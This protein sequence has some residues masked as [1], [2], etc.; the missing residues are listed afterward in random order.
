MEIGSILM[1]HEDDRINLLNV[2]FQVRL[3]IILSMHQLLHHIII[4]QNSIGYNINLMQSETYTQL[5]TFIQ[6]THTGCKPNLKSCLRT[7]GISVLFDLRL[8]LKRLYLSRVTQHL[9]AKSMY[10]HGKS[11]GMKRKARQ[12]S[13]F[14]KESRRLKIIIYQLIAY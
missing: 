8:W 4:Y 12:Y 9:K 6:T 11:S 1:F 2:L 5:C 10:G 7:L 3:Q 13:L 14:T